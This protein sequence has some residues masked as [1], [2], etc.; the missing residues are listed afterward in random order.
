MRRC[1]LSTRTSHRK[2]EG[3]QT[4]SILE[5][6]PLS[7]IRLHDENTKRIFSDFPNATS[8]TMLYKAARPYITYALTPA[9][10]KDGQ[11]VTRRSLPLSL[12]RTGGF[13]YMANIM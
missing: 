4:P 8:K 13:C 6:S 12:G 3:N 5:E 10:K 1:T 9:Y 7:V 11:E 2:T